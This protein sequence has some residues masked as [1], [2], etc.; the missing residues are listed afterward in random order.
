MTDSLTTIEVKFK[1]QVKFLEIAENESKNLFE[2]KRKY[3]L[4]EHLKHVE[5]CLEILQDLTYEGQE[6]MVS[7][8]E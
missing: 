7:G 4:E 6:R 1:K 3:E 8:D 5:T 2:R